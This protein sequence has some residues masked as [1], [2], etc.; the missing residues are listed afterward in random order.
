M[1]FFEVEASNEQ[2]QAAIVEQGDTFTPS[3]G[4]ALQRQDD[5]DQT[6][7]VLAAMSGTVTRVEN[8]PS[9]GNLVEITHDKGL[10]TVYYSLSGTTVAKGDEVL[11]GDVIAKAGRN[12]IEK[13]LGVHLHFEVLSNG[14]QVNPETFIVQNTQ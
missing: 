11:Q 2:K 4:I 13:N 5:H 1:P 6:F 10:V 7:D 14:E 8:I 12:E 9:V 3:M